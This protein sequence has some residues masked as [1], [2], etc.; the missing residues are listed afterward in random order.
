MGY[1]LG[2]DLGSSSVKASLVAIAS[3]K[4]VA[5][6]TEPPD[7]MAISA[8]RPGW[9]EQ[10]PE[11]WWR[12][13]KEATAM[14]QRDSQIDLQEVQ[15][16][17]ISYQMHGLVVVDRRQRVLRPA[18]IWC[19]SRAVTIGQQAFDALGNETCLER[20][21]NSPG[22]FTA[23]KLKWVQL[24]EPEIYN[25]IYKAMLPGEYIAM[26]LTGEIVTTA[27]G[28]SE[29]IY[30]DYQAQAPA[31]LLLDHYQIDPELLPEIAPLFAP[32]G[33][34]KPEVAAELGL[35]AGTQVAYR[36]GDQPNN[37]FSLNVLHPGEIAATAGTSAVVYGVGDRAT[38]DPP[39]RVNSFIHVNHTTA[40]PRYGVLLCIN[41]SAI[42]NRWLKTNTMAPDISYR[43]MDELVAKAPIG[44]AGLVFLPYGNG[45]ERSLTNRNIAASLHG[46]DFNLHTQAHLLRAAQ[47]GIVFA[48]NYGMAIMRQMGLR[49]TTVKA[50]HANMFLSPVFA[51]AFANTSGARLELY[52]TDGAQGAARGAG[53]GAGIYRDFT[54]AFTGLEA[55]KTV[56]PNPQ[57]SGLY[58]EAYQRWL[59][60]LDSV[61]ARCDVGGA[62]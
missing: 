57:I 45:A 55:I 2:F 31:R 23:S 58:Q 28:L 50:G 11:V 43:Q 4:T 22:N 16:I 10:D 33:S 41:G 3:G 48:M 21:L 13:V 49:L 52:K 32:Q 27:S 42:L 36:A 20:L 12:Y 61:K 15:A 56:E 54:E 14:L 47:E 25:Q 38:Y 60:I 24:N 44:S 7:E 29:G 34:L 39:S 8:P 51:E 18:I 59:Q 6:A 17:G 46:L 30:W 53:V 37:A 5:T 9:A 40:A 1:L 35:K 62:K 19:D 26:R